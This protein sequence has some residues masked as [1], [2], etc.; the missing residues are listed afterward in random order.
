MRP[1]RAKNN[2]TTPNTIVHRA[3]YEHANKHPQSNLRSENLG[4]KQT[5]SCS[6]VQRTSRVTCCVF[7]AS[8][9]RVL[10]SRARQLGNKRE[11]GLTVLTERRAP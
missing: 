7:L 10:G 11:S 4:G 6:R 2:H 1:A 3:K 5:N 9:G 8:R